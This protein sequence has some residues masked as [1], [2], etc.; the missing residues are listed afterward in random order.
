VQHENEK[1][2]LDQLYVNVASARILGTGTCKGSSACI[3]KIV[4]TVCVIHRENVNC[5]VNFGIRTVL[6]KK[7]VN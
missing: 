3:T 2:L 4:N 6:A 1:L 5:K 7:L